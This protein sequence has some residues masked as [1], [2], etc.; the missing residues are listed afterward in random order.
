MP[1]AMWPGV[2]RLVAALLGPRR[3][4][5]LTTPL[6]ATSMV[7]ALALTGETRRRRY[8]EALRTRAARR[9]RRDAC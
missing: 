1:E 6:N 7:V 5:T 8:V 2:E 3:T 4:A 9:A